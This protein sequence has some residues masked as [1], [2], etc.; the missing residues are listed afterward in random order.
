[1]VHLL[2]FRLLGVKAFS[3]LYVKGF[4]ATRSYDAIPLER[5]AFELE[6]R[7]LAVGEPF[8]VTAEVQNWITDGRL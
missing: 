7:F 6:T 3:R 8:N 4:F 5:C 1:M 2:Q